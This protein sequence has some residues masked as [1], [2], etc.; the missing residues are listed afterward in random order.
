MAGTK[1][2]G[3]KASITNKEKYGNG[4]YAMIGAKGGRKTGMKGFALNRALAI[5]AGRKGGKLGKRGKATR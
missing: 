3:I 4:F 2:G 1:E 5:E